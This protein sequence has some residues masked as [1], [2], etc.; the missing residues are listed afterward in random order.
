MRAW[1]TARARSGLPAVTVTV[2][3]STDP[4]A[5]VGLVLARLPDRPD[6]PR[7]L[8]VCSVLVGDEPAGAAERATVVV[9]PGT[10]VEFLPPFAG[11]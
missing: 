10:T 2:A 9:A 4:A 5:V 6:L 11:G 8:S 1:A 7:V 3:G